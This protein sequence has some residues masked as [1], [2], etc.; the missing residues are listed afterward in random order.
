MTYYMTN[1]NVSALNV[2]K[3]VFTLEKQFTDALHHDTIF[4]TTPASQL[5]DGTGLYKGR[6]QVQDFSSHVKSTGQQDY[7][8]SYPV[9][10]TLPAM[11][12][13]PNVDMQEQVFQLGKKQWGGRP[14]HIYSLVGIEDIS[15]QPNNYN[16]LEG[17]ISKAQMT[18]LVLEIES[19]MMSIAR[20]GQ[21]TASMGV[22]YKTPRLREKFLEIVQYFAK[23]PGMSPEKHAIKILV[24]L[25][26]YYELIN[27]SSWRYLENGPDG[28]SQ[29]AFGTLKAGTLFGL[30]IIP[31]VWLKPQGNEM[32]CIAL[33]RF[34]LAAAWYHM[35]RVEKSRHHKGLADLMSVDVRYY[36]GIGLQ[37]GLLNFSFDIN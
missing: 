18:A 31:T 16:N 22:S 21:Y 12:K 33:N 6:I 35:P 34:A 2:P 26:L 25:E 30:E 1:A 28:P 29:G 20:S 13:V 4:A 3:N 9:Y 19:D 8:F 32:P 23:I 17:Q 36:F 14:K 15:K 10:G 24:P 37:K 27:V 7:K 11:P 5:E